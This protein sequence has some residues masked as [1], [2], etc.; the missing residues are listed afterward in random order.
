MADKYKQK[1]IK[2]L[3]TFLS[4]LFF[5]FGVD[6]KTKDILQLTCQYNPNLIKKEQRNTGFLEDKNLDRLKI[7]RTFGC[8]DTVKVVKHDIENY[9][10]NEYRLINSWF[11][12]QGI[13]LDDFLITEESIFINTFVS[14]AFFL[15]SYSIDRVTNKTK[16]TFYKFDN[17]EIFFKIKEFEKNSKKKIPFYN[18][19]G[20]LSLKT[21]KLLSLEPIETYHFEGKCLIGTQVRFEIKKPLYLS[22]LDNKKDSK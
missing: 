13:L 1:I 4:I 20:K 12:H 16:R 11:N 21:L 14:Q 18:K 17:G 22:Y 10:E 19:K 8:E 15:E 6:S 9:D 7:C 5:S 3:L 2:T